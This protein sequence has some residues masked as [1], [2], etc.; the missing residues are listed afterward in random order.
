M[1]R[2]LG[3]DFLLPYLT[4]NNTPFFTAGSVQI[5]FCEDCNHAQ[6]PPDDICYACQGTNL[7]F[8]P[9]PG[10]GRVESCARVHHPIHPALKDKVPYVIAIIS[11]DALPAATCRAT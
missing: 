3:D 5:Q 8:A 10:T 11:V 7:V 2:Y 9:C 1:S 4:P 6:H